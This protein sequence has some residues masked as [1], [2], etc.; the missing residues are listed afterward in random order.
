MKMCFDYVGDS[1]GRTFSLSAEGPFLTPLFYL[2][3]FFFVILIFNFNLFLYVLVIYYPRLFFS[4]LFS[5]LW[6][7]FPYTTY[8]N[9]YTGHF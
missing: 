5:Y 1:T 3:F 9:E 7:R 4:G 8:S 2:L 6:H